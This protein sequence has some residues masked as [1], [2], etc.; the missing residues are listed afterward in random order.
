M[1]G[2]GY[3]GVTPGGNIGDSTLLGESRTAANLDPRI[4]SMGLLDTLRAILSGPVLHKPSPQWGYPHPN[5]LTD[6]GAIR[7]FTPNPAIDPLF[8]RP[9]I[10]NHPVPGTKNKFIRP[11]G[12]HNPPFPQT[13]GGRVNPVLAR[14]QAL[15]Q[16]AANARAQRIFNQGLA[17]L[18][19][20]R[21]LTPNQQL[22]LGGAYANANKQA[23]TAALGGGRT[24]LKHDPRAMAQANALAA[25]QRF[26]A[27]AANAAK[28]LAH[29]RKLI[30]LGHVASDHQ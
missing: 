8:E 17:N 6:P 23:V 1:P 26:A 29:G 11:A 15:A 22:A 7:G 21:R 10:H 28:N 9:D 14:K 2:Y 3:G 19:H 16:R 5:E 20:G 13:R 12:Y 30:R 18:S 27:I 24:N 25:A 4:S